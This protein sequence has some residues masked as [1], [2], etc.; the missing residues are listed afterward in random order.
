MYLTQVTEVCGTT[1]EMDHIPT[2]MSYSWTGFSSVRR[3]LSWLKVC[4]QL[5]NTT[6]YTQHRGI[7]KS[8]FICVAYLLAFD[9][10]PAM[11]DV[12]DKGTLRQFFLRVL[13]YSLGYIIPQRLPIYISFIFHPWPQLVEA[14]RYKSEGRGFDSRWC[15]WNFLLA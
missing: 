12:V 4:L 9:P 14:L 7:P 6:S 1:N 11:W 2:L 10:R 5:H 3:Q 13:L 8:K 15:N